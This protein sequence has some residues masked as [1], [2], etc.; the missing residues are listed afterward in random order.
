MVPAQAGGRM[1]GCET[2]PPDSRTDPRKASTPANPVHGKPQ[3]SGLSSLAIIGRR[4]PASS[5][6]VLAR[7]LTGANG[8]GRSSLT[9]DRRGGTGTSS[10]EETQ[11][12]SQPGDYQ[13][14]GSRQHALFDSEGPHGRLIC[15]RQSRKAE[16]RKG[17]NIR[18]YAARPLPTAGHRRSRLHPVRSCRGRRSTREQRPKPRV[19]VS[20]EHGH[21]FV[22]YGRPRCCRW[23]APAQHR[24]PGRP[25]QFCPTPPWP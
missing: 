1:G 19:K 3:P 24:V 13:V 18:R 17:T 9:P 8:C 12:N 4:S 5:S 6:F 23:K 25:A 22:A 20:I 21:R 14:T 11:H 16:A 15:A 7:A 10:Y 2:T